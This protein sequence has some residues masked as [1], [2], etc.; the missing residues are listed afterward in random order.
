MGQP[1]IAHVSKYD[2]FR[3]IRISA[4]FVSTDGLTPA[5]PSTVHFFSRNPLGSVSTYLYG[6]AGASVTRAG[7][8]AYYKEIT[9]DL[10]GSWYYRAQGT[11]GV[12]S[13][14]EWGAVCAPSFI[15]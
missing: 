1:S 9:L 15:L 13:A 8:G 14:E 7:A 3:L 12:Q 2:L 4:T 11:G 6:A 10:V 5:D